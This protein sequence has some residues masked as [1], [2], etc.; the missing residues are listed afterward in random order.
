MSLQQSFSS[1]AGPAPTAQSAR[2]WN[3]SSWVRTLLFG[4]FMAIAVTRTI[5]SVSQ[6][7]KELTRLHNLHDEAA[8]NMPRIR[9]E[10]IYQKTAERS[11]FKTGPTTSKGKTKELS[12]PAGEM[13]AV[14]NAKESVTADLKEVS[15]ETPRTPDKSVTSAQISPAMEKLAAETVKAIVTTS[16]RNETTQE[17]PLSA[18][19][20]EPASSNAATS[21]E[22]IV[23]PP[24]KEVPKKAP[25]AKDPK[26]P[27]QQKPKGATTVPEA[28]ELPSVSESQ[29]ST[30]KQSDTVVAPNAKVSKTAPAPK[31]K[32]SESVPVPTANETRAVH[33][34]KTVSKTAP[35]PKAK[36]SESVPVPTANETRAVHAPKTVPKTAPAPKAKEP[37]S[38]KA[39]ETKAAPAS[40]S[41]SNTETP[42]TPNATETISAN[43]TALVS[44]ATKQI[45]EFEHQEGAVIV[46]KL[47]GPHTVGLLA[48][49]LCLLTQAYNSRLDKPYDI[50]AF[51]TM[52][53]PFNH[54]GLVQ[55]REIVAPAKLTVVTDNAG[56]LQKQV[57]SLS[58]I[59]R[60]KFLSRCGVPNA[61]NMT[62]WAICAEERVGKGRI[63]YNWQA[64]FRTLHIW[65]HPALAQYNYMLWLDT[66]GFS[67]KVWDRDPVAIAM[68]NDLAIFFANYPQGRGRGED[69]QARIVKS[70]G[71][72]LCQVRM[73]EGHLI[74]KTG[75][76]CPNLAVWDVHG[77]M[78]ITNLN[79]YRSP[80]VQYFFKTLIGDCFCCRRF[81]DQLA[82]TVPAAMLAPN[83]SWD[84]YSHG[85]KLEV[86]HN[87][88]LDGKKKQAVGGFMNYWKN[89]GKTKFPEAWEKCKVTAG[90]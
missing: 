34:P 81:D 21:Q 4:G 15:S 3:Q 25:K 32:E 45:V 71:T 61:D 19:A 78:H 47:H 52:P 68:Q 13:P 18:K 58:E 24:A 90:G 89:N 16:A 40:K 55:I 86:F 9:D 30:A 17:R 67:T 26:N 22:T 23:T 46:T 53:I 85:V 7:E 48:Q 88:N 72:T 37:V 44:N 63:A 28:K 8:D 76:D 83:R 36:E 70:F 38:P 31:A 77:F 50:V 51:T 60:K 59:R 49:S 42:P 14:N 84:M 57:A 62:W 20:K 6:S 79:F 12:T 1:F 80:K 33:A 56:T 11:L 75:G 87:F 54:T 39:N 10:K 5:L 65:K 2:R 69:A 82:V 29:N 27:I 43:P 74:A 35:A 66:D 41:T 73:N 64:E